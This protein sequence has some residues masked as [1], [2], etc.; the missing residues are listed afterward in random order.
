MVLAVFDFD[1]TLFPKDTLPFLLSQWRVQKRSKRRLYATYLSVGG[2]YVRYKLG[3]VGALSRE[4]VRRSALQRFTRI[5]SGLP[6][7]DIDAFFERCAGLIAEQLRPCV[8]R[9]LR[10]AQAEGCHTVL[11]S[12]GYARLMDFVGG[13]MGFHTVIGTALRMKDGIVDASQT[14]DIV[15][16]EEKAERLRLKFDGQP[17]DWAQSRAFADSLSDVPIL[18]LVGHPVVVSP[19]E[20]LK[21]VIARNSW[22]V[23]A[24]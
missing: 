3:L 2:M 7:A 20:G 21:D 10:K 23:L 13:I 22:P 8:V 5:F 9:E 16:G 14:L 24:E 1:G 17:V 6:Q 4:Q 19:D 12:G 11:L 18:E 15:C